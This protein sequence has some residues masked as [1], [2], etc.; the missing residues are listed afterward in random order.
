MDAG[1]MQGM[2][3]QAD[4][5][6]GASR[7]YTQ[8]GLWFGA[9]QWTGCEAWAKREAAE[10]AEHATKWWA[11]LVDNG[12]VVNIGPQGEFRPFTPTT[13]IVEVFKAAR[14]LEVTLRDNINT[15]STQ[16][17]EVG[18]W[19]AVAFMREFLE[20]G[21]KQIRRL[22]EVIAKLQRAGNDQAATLLIDAEV[23]AGG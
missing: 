21:R 12:A 17:Q 7:A 1:L 10:E 19:D 5:E 4:R 20:A 14:A 23:G 18:E 9:N 6:H 11:F 8:Y 3:A 16:A 2:I 13:P 15:L 22:D